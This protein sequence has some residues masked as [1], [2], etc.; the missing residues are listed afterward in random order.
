[1]YGHLTC[2]FLKKSY[3]VPLTERWQLHP[4]MPEVSRQSSVCKSCLLSSMTHRCRLDKFLSTRYI[5]IK[6]DFQALFY[7]MKDEYLS[8]RTVI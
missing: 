1:M 6:L 2:R 7:W 5:L 3:C 8:R 4:N